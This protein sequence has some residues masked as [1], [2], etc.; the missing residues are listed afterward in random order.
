VHEHNHKEE[1]GAHD[2]YHAGH[3]AETHRH[4]H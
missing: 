4:T 2:H 1:H 3:D